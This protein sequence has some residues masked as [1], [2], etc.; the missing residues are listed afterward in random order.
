M[1]RRGD[2]PDPQMEGKERIET[3]LSG[4]ML[5]DGLP[6]LWLLCT[7]AGGGAGSAAAAAGGLSSAFCPDLSEDDGSNDCG[8]HQ[9]GDDGAGV[10]CEPAHF[11]ATFSV[12][13]VDS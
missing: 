2:M 4:W 3:L 11:T 10:F 5:S 8:K 13:F 6:D 7:A 9:A 12:S 1:S